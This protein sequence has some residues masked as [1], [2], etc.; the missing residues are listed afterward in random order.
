MI[1]KTLWM[2]SQF[3]LFPS[4]HVGRNLEQDIGNEIERQG[5]IIL[6]QYSFTAEGR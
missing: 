4:T 1:W 3:F 6:L 5:G 2:R